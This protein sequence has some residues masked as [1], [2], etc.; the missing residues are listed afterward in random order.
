MHSPMRCIFSGE[1]HECTNIVFKFWY[2]KQQWSRCNTTLCDSV[3]SAAHTCI[4][5][6][7][8]LFGGFKSESNKSTS[9]QCFDCQFDQSYRLAYSLPPSASLH[10]RAEVLNGQ[11]L[12]VCK[13]GEIAICSEE[14][15]VRVV[16]TIKNFDR[17]GFGMCSF[18]DKLLFCG[19]EVSFSSTKDMFLYDY[20]QRIVITMQETMP[21]SASNFSFTKGK[22]LRDY[23]VTECKTT[24][25]AM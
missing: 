15:S 23:L 1:N 4:G 8:Y 14:E 22:V 25:A 24:M 17:K 16:S 20:Q 13:N 6:K 10:A 5:K 2:E 12:L 7:V 3:R 11:M 21:V 19:G 18:E 9:I